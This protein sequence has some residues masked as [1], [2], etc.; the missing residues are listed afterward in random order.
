MRIL[1]YLGWFLLIIG[2]LFWA[3]AAFAFVA[4][5]TNNMADLEISWMAVILPSTLIQ[6]AVGAYLIKSFNS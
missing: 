1:F 2:F 3:G 6:I 4:V 5:G